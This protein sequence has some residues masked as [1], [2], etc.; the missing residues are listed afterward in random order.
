MPMPRFAP[1]LLAFA[2]I[3]AAAAAPSTAQAQER[4][5]VCF[6]KHIHFQ[7]RSYCIRVGE[8]VD[9]VGPRA[10][11]KFSSVS[12]PRGVVATMCEHANFRGRCVRLSRSEPDFVRMGFNDRVSAVSAEWEDRGGRDRGPRDWD[13]RGDRDFRDSRDF[14]RRREPDLDRRRYE[15]ARRDR[16]QV[17][18]YEHDHYRGERYCAPVGA[19]VPW[20]GD[21][22][23]DKFSSLQMPRG[24]VVTVCRDRNFGSTCTS[25]RNDVDFFPPGWNDT[26][27]SFRSQ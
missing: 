22:L 3:G 26:I 6:Y 8:R 12:V 23:N 20:V 25:F 1:L 19:A 16:G 21:R 24:V 15:D 27:S 2:L 7:G 9:F 13:R 17:C 11:D 18:F 10:N 14:D 5:S 4:S